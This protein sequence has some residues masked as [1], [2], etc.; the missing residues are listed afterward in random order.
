MSFS[1]PQLRKTR[2]KE[3]QV[4]CCYRIFNKKKIDHNDDHLKEDI[5]SDTNDNN[6]NDR[7]SSNP[8]S[9]CSI[10]KQDIDGH[11][12]SHLNSRTNDISGTIEETVALE[13][14]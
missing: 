10:H 3:K 12:K 7:V 2:T 9:S 4:C 6:N 5:N 14:F 1:T 11:H 13:S 8:S